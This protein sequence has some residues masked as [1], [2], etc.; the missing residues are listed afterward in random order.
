MTKEELKE[1][2]EHQEVLDSIK[3]ILKTGDG[4]KFLKYLFK[5]FDLL[6]LPELGLEGNFL[7]ERLGHLRAGNSIFKIAA[8]ADAETTAAILAQLEKDRQDEIYQASQTK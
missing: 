8:E 3:G 6:V 5:S 7:M 2:V 4:R 1:A